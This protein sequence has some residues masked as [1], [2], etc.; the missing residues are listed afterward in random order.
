MYYKYVETWK[1]VLAI[2]VNTT[3]PI[4]ISL[5]VIKVY[6]LGI[7]WKLEAQTWLP[8]SRT[9]KVL[10]KVNLVGWPIYMQ[11]KTLHSHNST[12]NKKV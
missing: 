9:Y 5:H 6:T 2:K 10:K 12:R 3:L 8:Y 1:E 4:I 11:V 7:Q